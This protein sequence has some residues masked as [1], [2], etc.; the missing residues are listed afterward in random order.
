[1]TM[2]LHITPYHLHQPPQSWF[3]W[4]YDVFRYITNIFFIWIQYGNT[5]FWWT[6][7]LTKVSSAWSLRDLNS[8]DTL[9]TKLMMVLSENIMMQYT[10][11][12]PKT[13]A[14]VDIGIRYAQQHSYKSYV[15]YT[16]YL[17]GIRYTITLYY[18]IMSCTT[19]LFCWI[20]L[21]V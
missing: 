2:Q 1:M 9:N 14:F 21:R 3:S 12:N 15:L 20:Q 6:I 8:K 18:N 17:C 13:N 7:L 10:V 11:V 16:L 5:R 4:I 19:V